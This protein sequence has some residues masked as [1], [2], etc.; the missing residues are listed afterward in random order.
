MQYIKVSGVDTFYGDEHD[1]E[2]LKTEKKLLAELHRLYKVTLLLNLNVQYSYPDLIFFIC[3]EAVVRRAYDVG[4]YRLPEVLALKPMT[5]KNVRV[6]LEMAM[7]NGTH[8]AKNIGAGEAPKKRTQTPVSV[9]AKPKPNRQKF[10]DWLK[11]MMR[12]ADQIDNLLVYD[13]YKERKMLQY[14]R[15]PPFRVPNAFIPKHPHCFGGKIWLFDPSFEMDLEL[16]ECFVA[17]DAALYTE[18]D[19]AK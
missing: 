5:V 15:Y 8:G 6:G 12:R 13:V 4:Y 10:N 11:E 14:Y 2:L 16:L 17:H 18:W 7:A 1:R 3:N 19:M 9:F